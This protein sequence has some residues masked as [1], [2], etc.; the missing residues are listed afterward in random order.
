MTVRCRRSA[1][2]LLALAAVL[3]GCGS[4][5]AR[6]PAPASAAPQRPTEAA[7]TSSSGL[8]T[9]A[10]D[11]ETGTAAGC[12]DAALVPLTVPPGATATWEGPKDLRLLVDSRVIGRGPSGHARIEP[13]PRR[14]RVAATGC[15][16]VRVGSFP[17]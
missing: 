7:G 13:G 1:A 11:L 3:A 4:H 12:G 14:L 5:D 6:P 16:A 17:G 8:Q 9:V 2:A 10:V 15:W